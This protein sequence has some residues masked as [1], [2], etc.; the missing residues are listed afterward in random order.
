MSEINFGN[1]NSCINLE[2]IFFESNYLTGFH[3]SVRGHVV[4][5]LEFGDDTNSTRIVGGKKA[6]EG[7][8]P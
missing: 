1:H 8:F 7:Q 6:E 4:Q 3:F 5:D 2:L